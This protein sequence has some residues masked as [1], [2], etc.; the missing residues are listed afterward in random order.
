MSLHAA[1]KCDKMQ[2]VDN[3]VG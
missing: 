3:Y 2:S 1:G